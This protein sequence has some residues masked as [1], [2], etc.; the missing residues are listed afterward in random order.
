VHGRS[1]SNGSRRRGQ[2]WLT[3]GVGALAV[4]VVALAIGGIW[5][6]MRVA[7]ARRAEE[8]VGRAELAAEACVDTNLQPGAS[9]EVWNLINRACKEL[10][11]KQA[12][13]ADCVLKLGGSQQAPEWLASAIGTCQ[14]GDWTRP[15]P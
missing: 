3:V 12:A 7:A 15:E 9:P 5:Y 11:D 10:H 1:T 14:A 8:H 4:A 2:F 13:K 6:M